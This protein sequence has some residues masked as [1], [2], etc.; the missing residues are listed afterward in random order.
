MVDAR[1][2][3]VANLPSNDRGNTQAGSFS[4]HLADDTR[5]AAADSLSD[6]VAHAKCDALANAHCHPCASATSNGHAAQQRDSMVD[7][8]RLS[9]LE[10]TRVADDRFSARS[11]TVMH[12][13]L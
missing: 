4:D 2:D 5:Y 6:G 3:S 8:D 1:A 12:C 10:S 9:N 7:A 11:T 13:C